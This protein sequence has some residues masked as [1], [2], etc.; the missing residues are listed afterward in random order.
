MIFDWNSQSWI[1]TDGQLISPVIVWTTHGQA[2]QVTSV[3]SGKQFMGEIQQMGDASI[4]TS[5]MGGT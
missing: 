2:G 5:S 3:G 4:M 1:P